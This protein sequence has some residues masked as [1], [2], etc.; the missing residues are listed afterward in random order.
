MKNAK[1]MIE[2]ALFATLASISWAP[3]ASA[4][5][6]PSESCRQCHQDEKFRV[7]NKKIYDYY[8]EWKGSAHDLAGLSC[9][10]CH[11]G[12]PTQASKEEAH[13]G[14]IPQSDL[15]SPFHFKNIPKTCGSCHA[16]ILERFAKSRHYDQLKSAGRGPNCITCHGSLNT[17]VYSRT[18][19]ERA[20][21]NCHNAKTGN[22]PEIAAQAQEILERLNHANGYRKGLKFYYKSIKKPE[23]MDKVDKAYADV[24]LFWHEFDFKS[25]RPRSKDLLAELKALYVAAHKDEAAK[26][27]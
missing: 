4:V 27:K 10:A 13:K 11:S 9:T 2:A 23:A 21:M 12:D 5:E 18:I 1:L 6:P 22:H 26:Q 8:Q 24:I 19:V 17:R 20:C 25:L 14:I 7:Q 3:R 15:N 16:P